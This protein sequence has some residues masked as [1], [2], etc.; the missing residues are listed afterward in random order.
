ML[1]QVLDYEI[2]NGTDQSELAMQVKSHIQGGWVPSGPLMDR[3]GT[4]L[5]VMLKFGSGREA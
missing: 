2:L 1:N 4:L 5:Q 3:G